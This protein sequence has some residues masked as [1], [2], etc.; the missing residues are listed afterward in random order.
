MADNTWQAIQWLTAILNYKLQA[1]GAGWGTPA[2]NQ[3]KSAAAD[4]YNKLRSN[5]FGDLAARAEASNA[6]GLR[7]YIN[8]PALD[9]AKRA[10][11]LP[12][13]AAVPVP[14]PPPPPIATAPAAGSEWGS[15]I[16]APAGVGQLI[17][18]IAQ[19]IAAP[20]AWLSQQI[21][22]VGP[23]VRYIVPALLGLAAIKAFG[24]SFRIS[25]ILGGR[26]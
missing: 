18:S 10:A 7:D 15:P 5:G 26:R 12:P 14:T 22:A 25:A 8:G 16:S 19:A 9:D 13:G 24:K 20:G 21:N 4:F 3:A 17:G 6:A 2:Y 1:E 23:F 11:G